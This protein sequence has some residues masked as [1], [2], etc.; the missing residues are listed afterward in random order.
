MSA[1]FRQAEI[2]LRQLFN[3]FQCHSHPDKTVGKNY[4]INPTFSVNQRGF[5]GG[6]GSG[7]GYDRWLVGGAGASMS[8]ADNNGF[9]S[10]LI[11]GASAACQH[12][13]EL[14][15][16][17]VGT[18]MTA[19]WEG[20]AQG[21]EFN[22]SGEGFNNYR[23]SPFT[24][25]AVAGIGVVDTI[26]V[27]GFNSGTLRNLKIEAGPVATQF[28]YPDNATELTKCLRYFQKS[29]SQTQSIAESTIVGAINTIGI[30]TG[31]AMGFSYKIEMRD[32]PAI[33][34]YSTLGVAG[35]VSPM[36][37]GADIGTV[38]TSESPYI[39]SASSLRLVD[40]GNGF[41]S[42]AFYRF[43]YTAEAEL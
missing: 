12:R 13:I 5:A 43:H 35:K 4:I 31:Q 27:L 3:D 17:P 39:S 6:V 15:T 40:S 24:F 9:V 11:A 20:T 37:G 26:A 34:I 18:V 7:Y 1:F 41:T 23:D 33:I 14:G 21:D 8:L 30:I 2:N 42:L 25:V 19:S 29:Y 32:V 28:E 10:L 22:S 38:V 36:S 16:V